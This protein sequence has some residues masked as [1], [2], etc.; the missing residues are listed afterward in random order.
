MK[1]VAKEELL[2]EIERL[3]SRKEI[4]EALRE[5]EFKFRTLFDSAGNAIF[6]MKD[7]KF[8][9]C[10]Q[11]ALKVFGCKKEQILGKSIAK[12]SPREQPE[13]NKSRELVQKKIDSTIAGRQQ[14][15]EWICLRYDGSPFWAEVT[16]N[17]FELNRKYF[18]L[19]IIRDITARKKAEQALQES[20]ERYRALFDGVSEGIL[21]ADIV[22]KRYILTN[23]AVH[24]M[25][26]YTKDEM[27]KLGVWDIHP[28]DSQKAVISQ[29]GSLVKGEKS[30]VTNI[31][32]RRKDGTVFYADFKASWAMIDAKE[33]L[34]SFFTDVTERRDALHAL[35][36]SEERLRTILNSL[37]V[38]I[39]IID[40]ETRIITDTNPAVAAMIGAPEEEIIG[41]PWHRF[42]CLPEK[43]SYPMLDLGEEANNSE[44]ILLN[45]KGEE[46][47][48]L[49]T[50]SQI[51]LSGQRYLL[52][53][54]IDISEKKTLEAQLIQAQKMEAVGR[55]AGGIAH[56][57]NNL[58]MAISGHTELILM[59]MEK[60]NPL[61]RRIEEIKKAGERAASLTRQL[62]AFSRKQM[63][64]PK[65]L[66]I[67]KLVSGIENMLKRLIGEDI[68]F[69]SSFNHDLHRIKADA[70]QIDQ[71]ILNLVINARDAMPGGGELI[72]ETENVM[73][74]KHFCELV[75]DAQPGHF[76]CLSIADSGIGMDQDLK[77]QI[78]DPFFT[79]KESGTGLGLSVVYGIVK[80]HGGWIKVYSAP[81][82]GSN[83]QIFFPVVYINPD[84]EIVEEISPEK[85]RGKGER[86][87]V[88]E[89]EDNV[90]QVTIEALIE[91]GY[92]VTDVASGKEAMAVFKK[93]KRKFKLAF[94]DIVLPDQTGLQ[95][96]EK[97][98]AINPKLKIVLTSG[99]PGQKSQ[100]AD[101]NK[102]G[103]IFIQKP[104]TLTSM[105]LSVKEALNK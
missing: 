2:K 98:L 94:C 6:I 95:L 101:I 4:E 30:L 39:I 87:L 38:G 61:R 34:V 92:E 96:V 11:K 10:N 20:E 77:R 8:A 12:F 103:Y 73:I 88:V 7:D 40:A 100:W 51:T 56:D 93:N 70:G 84:T 65:I 1:D 14:N 17:R 35:E 82:I 44:R 72:I 29:F 3:R 91:N 47:P 25:L 57:F 26:G 55:L 105:L 76:V 31:P 79:T 89:D 37:Q 36:E 43:E 54:L 69:L 86:I 66:D 75:P 9:D 62:L 46:I 21:V 23:P 90:R 68:R 83:F 49:K 63:M 45:A 102:K 85:L 15:F 27:K 64:K 48:I 32:C 71:I 58:L 41:S 81:G 97:F 50:V 53:S 22:T 74:D 33:C 42:V 60:D 19:A 99:Y 16:L 5:S 78:F 67:N 13:G 18:I 59:K 104:F 80:Q 52:E 28:K 24:R